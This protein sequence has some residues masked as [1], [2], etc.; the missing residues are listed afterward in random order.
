MTPALHRATIR[1]ALELQSTDLSEAPELAD[2]VADW[3]DA[4]PSEVPTCGDCLRVL[5]E[6]GQCPDGCAQPRQ[7][8][9]DGSCPSCLAS[10]REARRAARRM[11]EA[12]TL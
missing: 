10:E 8:S 4:L 1:L 6:D 3:L 11:A 7:C 5:D 2:A 9:C 12:E